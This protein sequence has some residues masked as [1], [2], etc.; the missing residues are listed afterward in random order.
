[1]SESSKAHA[2]AC[3]N[4]RA[5]DR[6]GGGIGVFWLWHEGMLEAD[7]RQSGPGISRNLA[8]GWFLEVTRSQDLAA[9]YA[10]GLPF[11]HQLQY[12]QRYSPALVKSQ[13]RGVLCIC[14]GDIS[15]VQ[16]S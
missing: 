10:A 3:V 4:A 1:M 7:W 9:S 15:T 5:Q 12:S 8:K 11:G 2:F 13:P 6:P 16:T 14:A